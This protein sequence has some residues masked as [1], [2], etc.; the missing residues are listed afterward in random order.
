MRRGIS[1]SMAP[2]VDPA[3]TA[4]AT[5]S[6]A[7]EQGQGFSSIEVAQDTSLTTLRAVG[8]EEALESF[9]EELSRIRN[10]SIGG[11]IPSP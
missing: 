5:A 10:V 4:T 3:K 11:L 2:A 9:E 6:A 8:R 7:Q 1:L